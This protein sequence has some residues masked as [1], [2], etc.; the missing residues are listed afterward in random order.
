M[1]DRVL[2]GI[3][4]GRDPGGQGRRFDARLG[5]VSAETLAQL[6]GERGRAE[7]DHHPVRVAGGDADGVIP[8]RRDRQRRLGRRQA[9]PVAVGLDQRTLELGALAREQR[10]Q[11]LCRLADLCGGPP[12]GPSVPALDHHRA[13]GADREL[14]GPAANRRHRRDAH[15]ERDRIAHADSQRPDRQADPAGL[16]A[17]RA[18]QREGVEGRHLP[19]PK[20][21]IPEL[22]CEPRR[23]ER[24]ERVAVLPQAQHGAEPTRRCYAEPPGSRSPGTQVAWKPIGTRAGSCTRQIGPAATSAASSTSTSERPSRSS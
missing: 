24:L 10:S 18:R 14:D 4:S 20:L 1:R 7:V 23:L 19:D 16:R 8:E 22:V 21:A 11:G 5:R 17:D 3:D 2:A 13:R 6:C 15:R 9:E 12:P